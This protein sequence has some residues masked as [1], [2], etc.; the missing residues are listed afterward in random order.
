MSK[1]IE[2][3]YKKKDI[4]LPLLR[5][6]LAKL[7]R[8]ADIQ[9]EFEH[10]IENG[11]YKDSPCISVE[12]YTAHSLASI[13]PYLEGEGAFMML[14]DLR[15]HPKRAKEKLKNGLKIK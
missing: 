8:N 7:D 13:S 6:K 10:W 1:I 14:I 2:N 9:K 11:C 4:P 5:Q 15:E 12:G 3:F